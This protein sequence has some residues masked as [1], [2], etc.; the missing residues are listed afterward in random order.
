MNCDRARRTLSERMD[1]E[2]L[3][4]RLAAALE[5]HLGTCAGCRTFEARAWALRERVRL[6]PAPLVPDL[7][8]PIMA[9]VRAGPR[10]SPQARGATRPEGP[11][12]SPAP[13]PA[14]GR[15]LLRRLA[16]QLAAALVG[17]LV[18][19]LAVGGPWTPERPATAEEVVT[20]VLRAA[21]EVS[22]YRAS[23]RIVERNLSPAVPLRELSMEVW[24][25]APER[26]RL[27]VVDHTVY[28]SRA[29]APTD[30]RLVVAGP[31]WY[32]RSPPPCPTCPPRESL[33]TNRAPF[34]ADTPTPADLVVPVATLSAPEGVRVLDRD[35]EA[36]RVAMPFE[37]AAPLF[38]FLRLGGTWRPIYPRDRVEVELDPETWAP[39]RWAVYPARGGERA[40]WALR[41]GL[42]SESPRHP[43]LEVDRITASAGPVSEADFRVPADVPVVDRGAIPLDLDE[44]PPASGVRLPERLGDLHLY[45]AVMSEA[46][47]GDRPAR[48]L[49]YAEGLRWLTVAETR[50]GGQAAGLAIHAQEVR[51]G[52]GVAYYEPATA[53]R[54]RRL[55]IHTP[56]GEIVLETNLPREDLLAVASSLPVRGLAL[57][58]PW[59][60]RETED[61]TV[62]RVTLAEARA[63]APFELLLP[64][65][66]PAGSVLASV[67][68]V[69]TDGRLGVTVYYQ[70]EDIALGNLRL[71][72]ELGAELP[73]T[74]E[75][76]VQT[77]DLDGVPARYSPDAGRLEWIADDRYISLE[78]PGLA[79]AELVAVARSLAPVADVPEGAEPSD[80]AGV[81]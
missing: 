45:R 6:S 10:P 17:V 67:E 28:P 21:A 11:P 38:P 1:G 35:R 16:P 32:L 54:G 73:P 34:S 55:A 47:A 9:A 18:G 36:V 56:R 42:P 52:N 5:A 27:D 30:L 69:R 33:I 49:A 80:T 25:R 26:F 23:F 60:V 22:A 37:R 59:L 48:I 39:L 76:V 13:R 12:S 61:G 31:T 43:I 2:Y 77:V 51:L 62:E 68:L 19:S 50:S 20:G 71:H 24:F 40:Q 53:E 8:E 14:P 72:L 79:L 41:F 66:L 57:P 74:T 15:P 29:V 7:V 58:E 78:A 63:A 70:G 44:L 46:A 81:P 75:P 64:T 65:E 4:R 3:P